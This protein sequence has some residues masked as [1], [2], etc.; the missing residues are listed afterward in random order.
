MSRPHSRNLNE[1]MSSSCF[2]FVVFASVF[3]VLGVL[4][5]TIL[6]FF[7]FLHVMERWGC[8]WVV[9]LVGIDYLGVGLIVRRMGEER[10]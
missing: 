7:V 2:S 10:Q 5:A 8:G 6:F 3:F 1:Q 9:F 4:W